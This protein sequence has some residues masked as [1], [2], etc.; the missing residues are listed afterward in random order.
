MGECL[1]RE[2]LLTNDSDPAKDKNSTTAKDDGV[3]NSHDEE[4]SSI[5]SISQFGSKDDSGQTSIMT[6]TFEGEK[7]ENQLANDD[8]GDTDVHVGIEMRPVVATERKEEDDVVDD[9]IEG[10]NDLDEELSVSSKK[11]GKKEMKKKKKLASFSCDASSGSSSRKK[12]TRSFKKS[13]SS[14]KKHR[15][16][17]EGKALLDNYVENDSDGGISSKGSLDNSGDDDDLDSGKDCLAKIEKAA[18][19]K[20]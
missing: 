9:L 6:D 13:T 7:R 3:N 2:A 1:S 19:A 4:K 8:G 17:T 15:A 20:N 12:S 5:K 11:K 18:Y 14:K 10:N 16:K